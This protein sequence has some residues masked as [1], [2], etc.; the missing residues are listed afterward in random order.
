MS[1]VTTAAPSD[2]AENRKVRILQRS[3]Q[4]SVIGTPVCLISIALWLSFNAAVCA[5]EPHSWISG[6]VCNW[7]QALPD[8]LGIIVVVALAFLVYEL[9]QYSEKILEPN[10]FANRH[11][12]IRPFLAAHNSYSRLERP[13]K[14]E[15]SLA[16]EMSAWLAAVTVSMLIFYWFEVSPPIGIVVIA[17]MLRIA[18]VWIR[19]IVTRMRE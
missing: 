11:V 16:L 6:F 17:G 15:V 8:L 10:K 14:D 3:K 4:I 18:Y 1:S 9:A 13:H 2:S 19:K 7:A 5:G 12:T